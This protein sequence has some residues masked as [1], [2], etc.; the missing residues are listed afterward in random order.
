MRYVTKLLGKLEKYWDKNPES[1]TEK[2]EVEDCWKHL[3]V[4][5]VIGILTI[6]GVIACL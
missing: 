4:L 5:L 3:E 6:I 1:D 2:E